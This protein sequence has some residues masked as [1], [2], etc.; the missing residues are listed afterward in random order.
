MSQYGITTLP[1]L[2]VDNL[3]V[4]AWSI[5]EKNELIDMLQDIH[6]QTNHQCCGWSC[7]YED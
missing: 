3:L 5:P 7:H 2:I 6:V 1:A 4:F